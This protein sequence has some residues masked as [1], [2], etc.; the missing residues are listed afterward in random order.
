MQVAVDVGQLRGHLTVGVVKGG[1]TVEHA[2]SV[3]QLGLGTAGC[4]D[5]HG[6]V[7]GAVLQAALEAAVA[8]GKVDGSIGGDGGL[9]S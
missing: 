4:Q 8:T 1:G 9:L 5:A 6:T 7:E 3:A 2:V